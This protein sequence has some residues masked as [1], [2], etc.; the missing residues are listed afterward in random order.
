MPDVIDASVRFLAAAVLL[1]SGAQKLVAPGA[2][3]QTLAALRL[4]SPP[5]LAVMV[6]AAEL[7]TAVLLLAAPRVWVTPTLVVALGASFAGA[8]ALALTRGESVRCACFGRGSETK[9]GSTQLA[10]LPVWL[11]VAWVTRSGSSELFDGISWV[12]VTALALSL[13][14]A[15]GQLLPQAL[16]SRSYLKVLE[17]QWVSSGSSSQH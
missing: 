5:V 6:G 1:Y 10:L 14:I 13:V 3:R 12:A 16:R 15:V 17:R 4:P 9:L 11:G 8:A 2:I 7:I